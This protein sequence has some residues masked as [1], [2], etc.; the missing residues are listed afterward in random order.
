MLTGLSTPKAIYSPS[1]I[2]DR[3]DDVFVMQN[4]AQGTEAV[5]QSLVELL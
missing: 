3:Y 1:L 4:L 5:K 2:I